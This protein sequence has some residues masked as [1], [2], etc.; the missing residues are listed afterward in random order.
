[1]DRQEFVSYAHNQIDAIAS[2]LGRHGVSGPSCSCG[3][4]APCPVASSLAERRDHFLNKIALAEATVQL[5]AVR[6]SPMQ[7]GKPKRRR[8]LR[9]LLPAALAPTRRGV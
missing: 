1:M 7:R 6:A 4:Q 2:I 3:R 9:A 8:G 5:P